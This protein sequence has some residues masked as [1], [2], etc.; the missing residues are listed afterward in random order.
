MLPNFIVIG[1]MKSGTTNLCHQ[2]SLHPEIF[3]SNPKEPCFFSNDD[4][5]QK[6]LSWYESHFDAVAKE[7]AIGE[8]S[9]NYSK[10]MEFPSSAERIR[11][12][13]DKELRIIY[14]VRNPL[15]QIRSKWMHMYVAGMTDKDFRQS[16][17]EDAHFVDSADY[18]LQLEQYRSF[19]PDEQIK[20][21]FFEDYMRDPSAVLRDCFA[22]LGVDES[23]DHIQLD[24]NK[25]T[26]ENRWGD[27]PLLAT[28]KKSSVYRSLKK[29]L[30]TSLIEKLR[31]LLQWRLEEK[32]DYDEQMRLHLQK[33]LAKSSSE[34]LVQYG[35]PADFWKGF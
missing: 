10:L 18:Q 33:H 5:W 31:P 9:V 15:D 4:R 35:K 27:S 3:I 13:F 2:L 26:H 17:L 16:V 23:F 22:F 1:A 21:L 11:Q 8:G 6:G 12:V 32:P 34:F 28:L 29:V 24:E 14:I 19:I 20:V 7:K 25:N 30:P